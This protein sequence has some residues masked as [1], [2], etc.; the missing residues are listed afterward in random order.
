MQYLKTNVEKKK[1]KVHA[2]QLGCDLYEM[3]FAFHCDNDRKYANIR[4][5]TKQSN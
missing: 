4:H 3:E 1:H 5:A 2:V